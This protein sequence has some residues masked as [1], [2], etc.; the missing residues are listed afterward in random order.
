MQFLVK[1]TIKYALSYKN[2]PVVLEG[3]SDA[4]WVSDLSEEKC[5]SGWIFTLGGGAISW[6]SK[7]Q[8][9]LTHSTMESEFVALATAIKEAEWLRDLLLEIPLWTKPM[10]AIS[11]FC[12]NE[13]ALSRA[14]NKVYNGKS[15][16]ISLRHGYI[17]EQFVTE[18]WLLSMSSQKEIWRIPLPK[19]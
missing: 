12:D 3:F 8:T 16:H 7:K 11:I 18:L 6:A 4:N 17:K 1:G 10:A 5:T 19:A 15:R 13:A 14:Y 9:L 2:Y